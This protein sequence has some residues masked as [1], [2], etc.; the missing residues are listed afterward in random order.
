M[1]IEER[2]D[3][4]SHCNRCGF[5]QVACPIF[6]ATGHEAGV[7]R[8][9]VALLRALIEKRIDW[10]EELK[11]PLFNCLLC[12]ACT[13]NCFPGVATAD[14]VVEARTEYLERVGREKLHRLLFN[15]LL[16]YPKRLRLAARAAGL[17]LK[18]GL[19]N[20]VGALGL[21]RAFGRD[22]PRAQKIVKRLPDQA[23]RDLVPPGVLEGRA[24]CGSGISWAA[25]STP[26]VRT[27]PSRRWACC[28]RWAAPSRCWRTVAVGCRR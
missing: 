16:P 27:P 5:C 9:R 8:G 24:N 11:E 19:S 13:A 4:I 10:T 22:F 12:G 1:D 2:Y 6:R 18:S 7:A 20:V 25:G 14:L 17:S 21:L 26:C 23:F 15:H 28:G 3:E